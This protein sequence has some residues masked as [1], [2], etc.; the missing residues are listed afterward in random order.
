M[1]RI[2]VPI[3]M[4][5]PQPFRAFVRLSAGETCG[6]IESSD[7]CAATIAV[8]SSVRARPDYI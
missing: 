7:F 4:N 3:D 5:P 2:I 8:R 1:I 6:G